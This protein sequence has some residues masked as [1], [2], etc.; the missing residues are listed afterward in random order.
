MGL[1]LLSLGYVLGRGEEFGQI[2]ENIK[3]MCRG[4]LE[5]FTRDH[6]PA[7][8]GRKAFEKY[9]ILGARGEAFNGLPSVSSVLAF[10]ENGIDDTALRRALQQ[11]II[12]TEDTVLLKR[13]GSYE[14][15]QAIKEEI[16]KTDVSNLSEVREMTR[17][18][19][20]G[21]LSP[22][23]SADLLITAVFLKE[24]RARYFTCVPNVVGAE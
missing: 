13:A 14:K 8:A 22:G 10:L 12:T 7:S 21:N 9:G 3:R 2:F 11:I 15:Y 1:S 23:G 6:A 24:I 16:G 19:V 18:A 4:I 5:E 20:A 17:K